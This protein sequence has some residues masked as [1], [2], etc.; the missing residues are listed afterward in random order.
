MIN[1]N[2]IYKCPN[3]G[4]QMD[5]NEPKCPHC[6]YINE[7]GAEAQYMNK[8]DDVRQRLDNVDEEAAAGY[9]KNYL[10]IVKI[11]A[12]TLVILIVLALGYIVLA[13]Y[14]EN[15][16][17]DNGNASG[18]DILKEM[19]WQRE[20]FPIYDKLYESGDYEKLVETVFSDETSSHD[21]WQ[22][23]HYNFARKYNDYVQIRN[24]I[25]KIDSEGW[26]EYYAKSITYS[27]FYYYFENYK[28]N[29][30]DKVSEEEEEILK[31]N[32]EYINN[33][34]HERLGYSDEDMEGL[35]DKIMSEYGNVMY[36]KC[37]KI[38]V[39]NMKNYK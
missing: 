15:K 33:V 5:I 34:L 26:N 3:C 32:I 30:A 21:I 39:K 36:D 13:R 38:A 6:G 35:K 25:E 24:M 17:M 1:M 16:I 9:G 27:C 29:S 20:N 28:T 18:D 2:N 31:P 14:I 22:W 4:A 12:I 10:K 19:S 11:M 23:E 37:E 7:T 8:L